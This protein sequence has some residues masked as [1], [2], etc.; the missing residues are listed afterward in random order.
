MYLT[1]RSA[2]ASC[3]LIRLPLEEEL[4]KEAIYG[5]TSQLSGSGDCHERN[6]DPSQARKMVTRSITACS[7]SF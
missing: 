4:M 6:Q 3:R 1:G 7:S 2:F 5:H